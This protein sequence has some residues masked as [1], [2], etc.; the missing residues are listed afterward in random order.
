VTAAI[1]IVPAKARFTL[2]PVAAFVG[3]AIA[4]A[5]L[6]LAAGAPTPLFVYFQHEW[7]FPA[8]LLTIAFA[9]YAIA[10][11]ASLLVAGSLSDHLGRRPVLIGA[12]AVELVAML[13]FVFA[14][15]I[16]WII[17]ARVVQGIATGVATSAFTASVVELAPAKYKRVG[18]I[19]GGVAAAGGL[20]VGALFSGIAIQFT[21]AADVIV[22]TTLAVIMAGGILVAIFSPETITPRGGVRASL[23]PRI[24]VPR[25]A[26]REFAAG[27]PVQVAAWMVAGL[28]LGLAPTIIRVI[29][30]ID[31]GLVN[32]L[33]TFGEPAAAALAGF[34]LGGLS[35]R[36]TAMIG[37]VG[38]ILGAAVIVLGVL[39]GNFPLFFIGGIIAGAGFGASFTGSLRTLG[40]LAEAHQR[41]GLFAGVYVVAY[42]AFGVPSII[43]GQLI[44]PLGLLPV[45]IV[46]G[47]VI[48]AV[49]VAGLVA[50][51]RIARA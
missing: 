19:I 47:L 50:Q 18:Q 17:A 5:A 26:R 10:L 42:L 51:A 7:G 16:G 44:A 38:V 40:P 14:P 9:A 3:T 45:I 4:F 2:P 15:D 49:A 22:F 23:V 21:S 33:T 43:V 1:E 27:V 31:S 48:L 25:A 20:G 8:S 35:A 28:F 6:Y 39:L 37:G 11:L 36:R 46:F 13:M 41:A 34:L 24:S 32:G 12:L 29:F 30:H